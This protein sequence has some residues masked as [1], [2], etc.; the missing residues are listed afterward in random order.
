MYAVIEIEGN[1]YL[2]EKGKKLK[3]DKLDSNNIPENKKLTFDK[4]LL[5]RNEKD[6]L[7]GTPYLKNVVVTAEYLQDV[8]AKKIIVFKYKRRKRYR[9][10]KGHRQQYSLI[11]ITDLVKK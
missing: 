2:V 9:S 10:K 6:I 8:K 11:K 4:V 7:I 1:Q 5:Y 3:I